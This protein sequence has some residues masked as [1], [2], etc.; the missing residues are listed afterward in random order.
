MRWMAIDHGTKKIGIAFCDELE[1]ISSP[2]GIW[3]MEGEA[4]LQKLA[5][6]VVAENVQAILVGLPL[7]KDGNESATAPHARKF[8]LALAQ[9]TGLNV[10]FVNEHLTS[11]EA[12]RLLSLSGKK[13]KGKDK[14][15][16]S[17]AAAVLLQAHIT[18]RQK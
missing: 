10:E 13:H 2:Y 6:L 17:A 1:I 4:T 9:R 12:K 14:N 11:C 15:L 7:H 8:G 18:S 16:D 5:E 3:P